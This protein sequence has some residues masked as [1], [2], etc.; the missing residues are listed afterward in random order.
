ML[1]FTQ[2]SSPPPYSVTCTTVDT[3]KH[4]NPMLE[5]SDNGA[6]SIPPN[7][8]QNDWPNSTTLNAPRGLAESGLQGYYTCRTEG[9]T[10]LS[11]HILH[12]SKYNTD[13]TLFVYDY[14]S[15]LFP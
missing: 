13:T 3:N 5:I 8:I 14:S 15:S 6:V 4:V 1:L 10:F 9:D 12:S 7:Y 2:H 11:P